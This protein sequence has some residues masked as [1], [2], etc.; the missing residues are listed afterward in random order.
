MAS[1]LSNCSLEGEFAF[2]PALSDRTVRLLL[3]DVG[4]IVTLPRLIRHLEQVAPRMSVRSVQLPRDR[5]RDALEAGDV[6]LAIVRDV[7]PDTGLLRQ[8]LY[9][10]RYV[11]LAR[12]DHPVIGSRLSLKKFLAASH[13]SVAMPGAGPGMFE[14]L[15]AA[16]GLSCRIALT[17]PHYLVAPL[18]VAKTDLM[19]AV[20][21]EILA[22]L[23]QP[24]DVRSFALPFPVERFSVHQYWHQRFDADPASR[25]LREQVHLLFAAARQ[26]APALATRP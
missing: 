26:A 9:D 3:S 8:H 1:Y 6:D 16:Q 22:E 15:V 11:C 19:V 4:E 25:W 23:P 24:L 20:P 5:H 2:D 7:R 13:I 10:D 17:V 21:E 12:R 14:Q 18:I